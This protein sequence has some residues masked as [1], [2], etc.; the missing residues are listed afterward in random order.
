MDPEARFHRVIL[1][2]AHLIKNHNSYMARGAHKLNAKYR[3]AMT[4]TPLQNRAEELYSIIRFLRIGPYD[5][6]DR[7]WGEIGGPLRFLS[8]RK[9]ETPRQRDALRKVN[10]FLDRIMLRRHKTSMINGKPI[11]SLPEKIELIE[12]TEFDED[13]K[14]FYKALE[15][16]TQEEI[17]RILTAGKGNMKSLGMVLLLHLLR[18]RQACCHRNL[19]IDYDPDTVVEEESEH[20]SRQLADS[21]AEGLSNSDSLDY[22][23]HHKAQPMRTAD[24]EMDDGSYNSKKKKKAVK[25]NQEYFSRLE[26]DYQPSAKVIRTLGLLK[27]IRQNNPEDKTIVFTF[28]TS[29]ID[30]LEIALR[31]EG[32]FKYCRFDGTM[33]SAQRDSAVAD[34]MEGDVTVFLASIKSG[35]VGL[36]LNKATHVIILDPFWNPYVEAQAVDRAYRIGQ[37]QTVT[38][39]RLLIEGTVEDRILQ[40]QEKKKKLVEAALGGIAGGNRTQQGASQLDRKEMLTLLGATRYDFE[41]RMRQW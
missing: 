40:L 10:G 11:I 12:A 39:H 28:F 24:F 4:G 3:L 15:N 32:G 5:N 13:E 27:S 19:L 18:L 8:P 41:E 2:E 30:I 29:F 26:R 34:F 31:R 1:D 37:K 9:P 20:D 33:N 14:C 16:D 25:R 36:N 35:N 17:R 6:W 21:D 23:G 7:F 22:P 38:V